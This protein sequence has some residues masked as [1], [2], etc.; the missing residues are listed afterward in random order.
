M[1]SKNTV[2]RKFFIFLFWERVNFWFFGFLCGVS[3]CSS[4]CVLFL[5]FLGVSKFGQTFSELINIT[6]WTRVSYFNIDYVFAFGRTINWFFRVWFFSWE[7]LFLLFSIWRA[8]GC[9]V[10]S[11]VNEYW[12]SISRTHSKSP[13]FFLTC[14]SRLAGNN[15]VKYLTNSENIIS[16]R[17]TNSKLNTQVLKGMKLG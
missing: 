10:L 16:S 13:D 3:I 6:C 9:S 5:K 15:S 7:K 11:T 4:L 2:S 1:L 12:V 17:L 14:S 8:F